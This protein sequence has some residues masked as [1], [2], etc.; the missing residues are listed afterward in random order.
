MSTTNNPRTESEAFSIPADHPALPGHF[1]Q[2]PVVP[3]VMLLDRVVAA[4]Q[5]RRNQPI[6]GLPQVKFLQPLLPDQ[7]ARL[8][9]VDSG[10]NVRF[11]ITCGDTTIASG[12]VEVA[13]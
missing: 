13:R 10:Q 1:P 3:G 11:S 5:R 9:I 7:T 6:I 12:V 2:A 8:S 4:I